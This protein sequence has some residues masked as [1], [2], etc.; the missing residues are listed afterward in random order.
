[1]KKPRYQNG[2]LY[3]TPSG[4]IR[5][6]YWTTV[7]DSTTTDG[8][9][10]KRIRK[11]VFI[12][13]QD[14]RHSAK[15][16]TDGTVTFSASVLQIRDRLM[17]DV[18][19]RQAAFHQKIEVTGLTGTG[20]IYGNIRTIQGFYE[21]VYLPWAMSEL[22]KS[23]VRSYSQI[24]RTYLKGHFGSLTFLDYTTVTASKYL[25][26][27]AEKG[28]TAKSISH[29]RAV[30]SCIFSYALAHHGLIPS[31]PWDS[32]KSAKKYKKS[33]PT[34]F[35]TVQEAIGIIAALSAD[36]PDWAALVGLCF[37]TGLRPSEAIAVRWED[38]RQKNGMWHVS[39]SRGCVEGD[40]AET[41]TADSKQSVP[42]ASQL[43]A[44]LTVWHAKSG[45]GLKK[46][47]GWVF[48]GERSGRNLALAKEGKPIDLRNLGQ[49]K[50]KQAVRAAGFPWYGLY[51]FRRGLATH[52]NSLGDIVAAQSMLRHATPDTTEQF[53][54]KLTAAD[55]LRALK[56][57]EAGTK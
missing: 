3:L 26:S 43:V 55:K 36:H 11:D 33:S 6:K 29:I 4:S 22:R 28:L 48:P 57:L 56:Y 30:A 18:N 10:T 8:A 47:S 35:Y 45:Q 14:G 19:E 9:N 38:F 13:Q 41:K 20:T 23:T 51:A 5:C 21:N 16:D 46:T 49:R 54:A 44:L 50:L 34:G 52:L 37:Y 42:M 25:T 12:A 27:L 2:Q 17:L 40:V 31:N 15:R 1:M 7:C 39:I 53:Y 24:W 32:A